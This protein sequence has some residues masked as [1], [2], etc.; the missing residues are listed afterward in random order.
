M[1]TNL[2]IVMDNCAIHHVSDLIQQT[3]ALIYWLPP[4]SPDITPI[5]HAFKAKAMMKAMENEMEAWMD[6]DMIVYSAFSTITT[7]DCENW[8]AETGM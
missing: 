3:R 7:C 8:I 1:G 2:L 5:E 4:C 6:I